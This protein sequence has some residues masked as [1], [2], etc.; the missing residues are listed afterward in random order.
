VL[1]NDEELY[2]APLTESLDA[3]GR[4]VVPAELT[5][6]FWDKSLTVTY[7]I[8]DETGNRANDVIRMT[9]FDV[10]LADTEAQ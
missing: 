10:S 9:G 1:V 3:S 6:M 2:S 8:T 4:L 5:S 7:K